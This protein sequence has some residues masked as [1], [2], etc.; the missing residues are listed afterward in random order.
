MLWRNKC[1]SHCRYTP[2]FWNMVRVSH[3]AKRDHSRSIPRW[4]L[5]LHWQVSK[6]HAGRFFHSC[7]LFPFLPGLIMAS[8]AIC[9]LNALFWIIGCSR[10]V[11]VQTP[12]H[13]HDLWV[14][15][16]FN[17][18]HIPVTSLAIQSCRDMRAMDKMDKVWH[19]SNRHPGN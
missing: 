10:S 18:R 13:V 9:E 11:A 4:S 2:A 8:T 7:Q 17:L 14:L 3:N 19:L 15:G 16:N 12:T 1:S 5:H 6:N